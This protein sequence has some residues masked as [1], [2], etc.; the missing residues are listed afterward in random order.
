MSLIFSLSLLRQ[1][2]YRQWDKAFD[3]GLGNFATRDCEE[4]ELANVGEKMQRSGSP[5]LVV[6]RV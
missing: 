3:N 1:I 2:Y 6:Y 4:E 5:I